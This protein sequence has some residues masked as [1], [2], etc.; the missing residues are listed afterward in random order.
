MY[1]FILFAQ[2][3]EILIRQLNEIPKVSDLPDKIERDLNILNLSQ[4]LQTFI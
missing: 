3:I 4:E 1:L 2:L